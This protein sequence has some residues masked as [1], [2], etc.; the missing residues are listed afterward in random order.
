MAG[1]VLCL[2]DYLFLVRKLISKRRMALTA[3]PIWPESPSMGMSIPGNS[4]LKGSYYH[5][6]FENFFHRTYYRVQNGLTVCEGVLYYGFQAT[7]FG[8]PELLSV[9]S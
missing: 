2:V 6:C 9:A 8:K 4:L 5:K 7:I 1:P 3:K